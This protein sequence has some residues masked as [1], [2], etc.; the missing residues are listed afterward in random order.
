MQ[1]PDQNAC[2]IRLDR[3]NI[4]NKRL[5]HASK[6][7]TT[8]ATSPIYFYNNH[9]KQMQHTAET[10][11]TLE[12]YICN[13]GEAKCLCRLI[14]AVG[15]GAGDAWAP[16]ASS[17][18]GTREHHR[19]QHRAWLGQAGSVCD[20]WRAVCVTEGGEWRARRG[21]RAAADG[22]AVAARR[23]CVRVQDGATA[24]LCGKGGGSGRDKD[25]RFF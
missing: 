8:Y 17:T 22:G 24:M 3:R 9:M 7:L 23:L 12:T 16:L 13:M 14:L 19:H 6:T 25:G 1:Y 18:S 11:E 4:L 5:Q 10:S 2:N 21:K 15:V 20:R